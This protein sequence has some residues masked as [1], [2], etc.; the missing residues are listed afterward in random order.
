MVKVLNIKSLYGLGAEITNKRV[1]ITQSL[2]FND[3]ITQIIEFT[4]C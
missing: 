4:T 1:Q 3:K 2:W